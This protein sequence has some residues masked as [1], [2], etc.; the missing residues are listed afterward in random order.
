M[1][2]EEELNSCITPIVLRSVFRIVGLLWIIEI[3]N[4]YKFEMDSEDTQWKGKVPWYNITIWGGK[5]SNL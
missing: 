3:N 4:H 1:A 2:S 5:W